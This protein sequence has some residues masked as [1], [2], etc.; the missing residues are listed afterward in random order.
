[1][2]KSK[3]FS[4][5]PD[6]REIEKLVGK[7][8]NILKS[9]DFSKGSIKTQIMIIQELIKNGIKVGNL[10]PSESEI[11]V[12]L[13]ISDNTITIEVK[14]PVNETCTENLKHLDKTIQF[15]RG[16]QDPFEAYLIMQNKTMTNKNR[17]EVRGLNLAKIAYE[18]QALL[19][20]YVSDDNILNQS[21]V[22]SV[23][24]NLA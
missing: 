9:F 24:S 8:E 20:F 14:N 7:I 22:R 16:F 18:G 12:C 19:D 13:S 23:T 10:N 4:F 21:A 5:M 1:M 2:P 11:T 15:I 17:E 6:P 3:K